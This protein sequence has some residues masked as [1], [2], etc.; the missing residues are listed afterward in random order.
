M[1][2]SSLLRVLYSALARVQLPSAVA[3]SALSIVL[4]A[5]AQQPPPSREQQ[6]PTA[7]QTPPG[8]TPPVSVQP[9]AQ[10]PATAPSSNETELPPVVVTASRPK[11]K[12]KAKPN[13]GA[14]QRTAQQAN[15]P[16]AAQAALDAKM[17]AFDQARDNVLPKIGATSY[18]INREAIETLP[19][20]DNTPIDKVILQMPGVS[21]DSAVSN[22]DF[23]VRNEYANVQYRING[24]VIPEGVSVARSGARHQFYRQLVAAHRHA[25]RPSMGCAPPASSISP[26]EAL[27]R[28]AARSVSMA[29]A[30]RPTRRASTTAAASAIPSILSAP[31]A[32]GTRLGWKIRHPAPTPTTITPSKANSSAIRRRC[33]TN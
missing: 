20:G 12:P 27:P 25:A 21:Y 8:A 17:N 6:A 1:S 18:T 11:P 23:H 16:T 22:P 15:A 28:P 31:A 32:I 10:T 24:V 29:A 26:A 14:A 4:G 5:N 3:F 19:Q 7:E 30:T 33:S 13:T 9:T 2:R